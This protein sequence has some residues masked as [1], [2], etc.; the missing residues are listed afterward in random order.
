M[1]DEPPPAYV[2]EISGQGVAWA[3]MKE[4]RTPQFRAFEEPALTI[5]PLRDNVTRP[6]AFGRF[7]AGLVP[8]NGGRRREAALILPDYSTRV[9][10]LDF[11][12]FPSDPVEQLALVRFRLKK[13]VPFEMDA[14]T[15][16]FDARP[17]GK[18]TEA[19][20]AVVSQDIVS[21][22]EAP[23][24]AAGFEPG[25]VTTS[26]LSAVDL[27][28]AS[29]VAL[30]VKL[31]GNV[32]TIT[33]CEGRFP[34]LLRS[35]ELETGSLDE[36]MNVLYPTIAYAEDEMPNKPDG[37]HVVGFGDNTTAICEHLDRELRMTA[38]PLRSARGTPAAYNAGLLGYLQAQ[39]NRS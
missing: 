6:E 12:S 20:T 33:L 15:V 9:T 11:E 17:A 37:I 32:V 36:L 3:A 28:P 1:V 5:S 23:F 13:T 21:H 26:M 8:A 35:V 24:R 7:V 34:K 25:L 10:V 14:A 38:Q 39:E 4:G 19:V 22:Y 30:V 27:L 29:G 31:S 2:F 18:K 16:S